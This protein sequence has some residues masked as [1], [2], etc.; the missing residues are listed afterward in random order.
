MAT[1]YIQTDTA[2]A[3]S[4]AAYLSETALS[5]N[6]SASSTLSVS[7]PANSTNTLAF[8]FTEPASS[9][10]GVTDWPS[11]S[12]YTT[13]VN[14]AVAGASTSWACVWVRYSAD[15]ATGRTLGNS[16]GN[17]FTGTGL[18]A[19]PTLATFNPNTDAARAATDRHG[20][21]IW[22]TN[23]SM[24]A[25]A[26]TTLTVNTVDSYSI[27]PWTQSAAATA[28]PPLVGVGNRLSRLEAVHRAS[29]W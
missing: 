2:Q 14:V 1:T 7:I 8:L 24:S 11:G 19:N 21:G 3:A 28:Q 27:V 25:A 22:I 6:T 29:R 5:L 13:Q 15:L 9:A 4:A 18:K 16:G 12:V 17:T 10:A 20:F 26:T 23:T